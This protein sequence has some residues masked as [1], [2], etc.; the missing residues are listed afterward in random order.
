MNHW[1]IFF[2]MR[3]Y[4]RLQAKNVKLSAK[5]EKLRADQVSIKP[6]LDKLR[7]DLQKLGIAP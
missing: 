4:R 3:K 2:G 5:R 1:Q 7:E 6:K